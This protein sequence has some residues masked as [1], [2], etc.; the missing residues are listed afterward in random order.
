MELNT[1]LGQGYKCVLLCWGIH[2]YGSLYRRL[3]N[4]FGHTLCILQEFGQILEGLRPQLWTR[5]FEKEALMGP[6]STRPYHVN[7]AAHPNL[8]P[9][10]SHIQ[11]MLLFYGRR[12]IVICSF[13]EE[14]GNLKER[15]L[16]LSE[17]QVAPSKWRS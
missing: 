12:L 6:S 11:T 4:A 2:D 9:K 1:C 7:M 13:P 16:D 17:L 14:V 3:C 10:I 15:F 8:H 5:A